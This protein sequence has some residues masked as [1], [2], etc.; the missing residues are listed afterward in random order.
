M[1]TLRDWLA[2][3]VAPHDK[4]LAVASG[5]CRCHQHVASAR[6]TWHGQLWPV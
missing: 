5:K 6:S 3:E 4:G 2:W 1:V